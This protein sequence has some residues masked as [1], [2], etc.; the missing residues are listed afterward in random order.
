MG[1]HNLHKG[2]KTDFHLIQ[3]IFYSDLY[4]EFLNWSLPIVILE[5]K[6]YYIL[7]GGRELQ[8]GYFILNINKLVQLHQSFKKE[9]LQDSKQTQHSRNYRFKKE[10]TN[11]HINR[12]MSTL[13][14][15]EWFI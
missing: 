11:H 15:S 1:E 6:L 8:N 13:L 12:K 3:G 2:K 7:A 14:F 9:L 5:N 4:T 10:N